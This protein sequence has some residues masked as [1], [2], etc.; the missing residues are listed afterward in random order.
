MSEARTNSDDSTNLPP[1]PGSE[2]TESSTVIPSAY[3]LALEDI[4]PINLFLMII[5]YMW[6]SWGWIADIA[7]HLLR[8]PV[9]PMCL[10]RRLVGTVT[11]TLKL[12]VQR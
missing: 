3:D 6:G 2:G 9:T 12:T 5:S 10:Q 1:R 4:N 7:I 8:I 11:S